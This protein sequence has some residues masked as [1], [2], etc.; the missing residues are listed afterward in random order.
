MSNKSIDAL[1]PFR[2]E[3][4]P[5]QAGMSCAGSADKTD[6]ASTSTIEEGEKVY[7]FEEKRQEGE[8]AE[9]CFLSF[10]ERW[11]RQGKIRDYIDVRK[12]AKYQKEDIDFICVMPDGTKKTYEVKGDFTETG[13]MFAEYVVPTYHLD[14]KHEI[15]DRSAKTGWF[16]RSKADF[17]FYY[18]IKKK[19]V[20]M[21]ALI[22][23][24][25]WVD[26]MVLPQNIKKRK[27]KSSYQVRSALN[28]ETENNP[29][30]S[31]Y[32]GMG[33]LLPVKEIEAANRKLPPKDR[34]LKIYH[35]K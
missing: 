20:Y 6:E 12:N 11:K 8:L 13:N 28:I 26:S 1:G 7:S 2:C 9:A 19:V 18:F 25:A 17:V 10:A 30:G 22:K 24:C 5:G 34:F 3:L 29:N 27:Q 23:F 21:V 4:Q 14:E 15:Q 33:Y 31:Y 35:L 16:Y 32:Y